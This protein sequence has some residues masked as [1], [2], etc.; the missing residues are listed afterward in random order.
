MKDVRHLL[1]G[2]AMVLAVLDTGVASAASVLGIPN[3][4]GVFVPDFSDNV[5]S[6]RA[7]V[8]IS[9]GTCD[10]TSFTQDLYIIIWSGRLDNSSAELNSLNMKNAYSTL[11]AALLSGKTVEIQGLPNCSPNERGE[12]FL[13]LP[14]ANV[15]I[16]Q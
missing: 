3:F 8:R 13:D 1:L 2:V 9:N 11:L 6:A 16:L 10:N 7:R 15:S 14:T 4:V 5:F 12:I